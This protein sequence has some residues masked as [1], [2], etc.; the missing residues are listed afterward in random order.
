MKKVFIITE[1]PNTL[2][3][4][5][6]DLSDLKVGERYILTNWSYIL[7]G[8]EVYRLSKDNGKGVSGNMKDIY[9]YHGWRGTTNN[10]AVYAMGV[11]RV[12]E[13]HWIKDGKAK[14][15]LS[16]DLVPHLE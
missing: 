3:G 14:V 11:R 15:K 16:G 1:S 9:R 8:R 10:C 5:G 2:Y 4:Y 6:L 12:E 7:S 13:I